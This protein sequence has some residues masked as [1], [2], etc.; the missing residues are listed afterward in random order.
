M[1]GT[2]TALDTVLN[3]ARA[4]AESRA[5]A[6]A[7]DHS[8]TALAPQPAQS[9][10]ARPGANFINS[11]GIDVDTYLKVDKAGFKLGDTFKGFVAEVDVTIDL[12]EVVY[13]YQCRAEHPATGKI[14]YLKSYDGITTNEGKNFLTEVQRL[15]TSMVKSTGVYETAE[16]PMTIVSSIKDPRSTAVAEEGT[17][18][19]LTPAPTGIKPFRR[20]L[21][22]VASAGGD[23]TMDV[24]RVRLKHDTKS[25]SNN[26]EYGVLV[27]ELL[28]D[29]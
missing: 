1:T 14:V 8:T 3:Q 7:L 15:E 16:I 13:I 18:L 2:A 5:L 19:G 11:G 20:L 28:A 24:I 12:S 10:L 17:T 21:K 22:Q 9:A 26:Q 23:P 6:P 27:Y 4:A 29:A 25:N